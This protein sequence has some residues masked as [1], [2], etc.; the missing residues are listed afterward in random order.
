MPL[1]A[2]ASRAKRASGACSSAVA[3]ARSAVNPSAGESAPSSRIR[4]RLSFRS[5]PIGLLMFS[6]SESKEGR[7]P[8]EMGS[9]MVIFLSIGAGFPK[10]RIEARRGG[11]LSGPHFTWMLLLDLDRR[12]P[13][14]PVAGAEL[15]G[16][17]GVQSPED[18]LGVPA[19][20]QVIDADPS[21]DPVGIDDVG[22]AERHLLFGVKDAQL[23]AERLL[24]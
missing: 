16:L 6:K 9:D 4:L 22:G 20:A 17:E 3:V 19:D 18:L 2:S 8:S 11:S 5:R 21:D 1:F 23:L 24:V 15:V 13:F 10:P 12:F 14:F 7:V